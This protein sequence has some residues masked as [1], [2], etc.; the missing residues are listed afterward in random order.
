MYQH[1]FVRYTSSHYHR[2]GSIWFYLP[3]LLI[4]T[5]PWT[6]APLLKKPDTATPARRILFSQCVCWLF[7]ALIFFSFSKSKLPGYILPVIPA[8]AMLAGVTLVDSIQNRYGKNRWIWVFAIW[9]IAI[10]AV[11][12][13]A[14]RKF[15][16]V[17]GPVRTFSVLE[18]LFTTI[19]F[20]FAWRRMF[21]ASMFTYS[22]ILISALLITVHSLPDKLNWYESRQLSRQ[23][24]PQLTGNRKL[25]FYNIYDF[26]PLFYTNGRVELTPE[27]YLYN[28]END[29]QLYRYLA[30]KKEAF[31][32]VG[33]EELS[34]INA[35]EFWRVIDVI[36]GKQNSIVHLQLK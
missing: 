31:V 19:A 33:N 4:G 25:V 32:V 21:V 17:T 9:N 23:A 5:F 26:G 2:S 27:G 34:W 24:L 28:I 22:L 18:A 7:S 12:F 35:A 20:L 16:E 13:F 8:F 10:A 30:E 29:R 14:S 6:L 1:H 3:V 36:H 11:L 15:P